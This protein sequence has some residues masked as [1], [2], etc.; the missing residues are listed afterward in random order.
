MNT[1]SFTL[2]YTRETINQLLD[3]PLSNEEWNDLSNPNFIQHHD[4]MHTESIGNLLDRGLNYIA[5]LVDELRDEGSLGVIEPIEA[6][7]ID[8]VVTITDLH[9]NIVR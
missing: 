1:F 7:N 9:E 6:I 2:E 3:R 5:D 4:A 8:S